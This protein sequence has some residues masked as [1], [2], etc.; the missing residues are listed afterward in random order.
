MHKIGTF[1]TG[2]I[3]IEISADDRREL[4]RALPTLERLCEAVGIGKS[5]HLELVEE[6]RPS[7]AGASE[8]PQ[9]IAAK[10]FAPP[11]TAP[12]ARYCAMPSCRKAQKAEWQRRYQSKRAA[13]DAKA[14]APKPEPKTQYLPRPKPVVDA[15]AGTDRVR[16]IMKRVQAREIAESGIPHDPLTGQ[17]MRVGS[18]DE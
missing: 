13:K 18:G 3:V 8:A 1:V 2:G 15:P 17:A 5:N 12:K 14:P 11:R 4:E 9:G 6:K 16:Q 7:E 10:P